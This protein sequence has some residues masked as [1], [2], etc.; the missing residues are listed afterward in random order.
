MLFIYATLLY[1]IGQF[2]MA[3]LRAWRASMIFMDM[4]VHRWLPWI[5]LV[6][7]FYPFHDVAYSFLI[8]YYY[9]KQNYNAIWILHNYLFP[10]FNMYCI[11]YFYICFDRSIPLQ[12][13]P[14]WLTW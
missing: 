10:Y 9:I 2:E 11:F 5:A 8:F 3:R 13:R 6:Y 14:I 1:R 7:I 12:S 4:P